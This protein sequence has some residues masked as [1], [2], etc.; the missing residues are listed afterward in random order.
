MP[1]LDTFLVIVVVAGLIGFLIEMRSMLL[2]LHVRLE[3]VMKR[4]GLS[5]D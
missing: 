5:D 2:G 3:S 4:L 1:S